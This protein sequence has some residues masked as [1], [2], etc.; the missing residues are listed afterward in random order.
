MSKHRRG[1]EDA[2]ARIQQGDWSARPPQEPV[3]SDPK[4]D[5]AVPAVQMPVELVAML[6]GTLEK[7]QDKF[8]RDPTDAESRDALTAILREHG[9]ALKSVLRPENQLHPDVSAYNPLGERDHPRPRLKRPC[10]FLGV[11]LD[12]PNLDREEIDLLNAFTQSME[13]P[14]MNW[15]AVFIR[16]GSGREALY[17]SVPFSSFDDLRGLGSIK[18]ICRTI[19]GQGT[20]PQNPDVLLERIN[21]LEAALAKAGIQTEPAPAAA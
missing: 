2:L 6:M 21:A 20:R 3:V 14:S 1:N 10:Y 15:K 7:L 17:L 9:S 12:A 8:D 4:P 16:D 19:Q 11:P 5:V 18:H 13:V